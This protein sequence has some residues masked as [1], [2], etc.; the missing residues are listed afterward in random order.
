MT[1]KSTP[2]HAQALKPAAKNQGTKECIALLTNAMEHGKTIFIKVHAAE[3]LIFNNYYTGIDACFKKLVK[4]PGNQI[5][6]TRVLART[7]KKDDK[8]YRSYINALRYQ[9]EHADSV[10]GRLIALE[11]LGKLGFDTP[12]PLIKSLADTGT[13]GFRAMAR[14][15]LA[16]SGKAADEA[17]L[18]AMLASDDPADYRTAAYALRF[19]N[20]IRPETLP[21]LSDCANRVEK[22]H[23]ARVYVISSLFVH[24]PA[25]QV[26]HDTKAKLL[27]YLTGATGEKYEV[28][29]ALALA[30]KQEDIPAVKQLL[31]DENNDVRVAAAKAMLSIQ[32]KNNN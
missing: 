27:E 29:E 13:S 32:S 16:N 12:L 24:A 22:D 9:L 28:A 15:V 7:N 31:A 17:Q 8:K 14:W 1:V 23:P 30:G 20:T 4:E 18:A 11:S 2:K 26:R 5:I 25:T 3:A 21:L 6:A 19:L 10:R